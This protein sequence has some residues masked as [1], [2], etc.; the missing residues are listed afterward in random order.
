MNNEINEYIKKHKR[1]KIRK[2]LILFFAFFFSITILI[3]LKA[4]F[5][6]IQ[7]VKVENNKVINSKEIIDKSE[8]YGKN[9]FYI[10]QKDVRSKIEANPYIDGV[11]L[12]RVLPN[13]IVINV[14]ERKTVYFFKNSDG[15]YVLNSELKIL[16]K[17]DNIDG[18]SLTE[19]TGITPTATEVGAYLSNDEKV[20]RIATNIGKYLETNRS[21]VKFNSLQIK[22]PTSI[23]MTVGDV[24]ILLGTDENL[25]DKFNSCIR[26]LKDNNIG[27]KKGYIDVSFDGEP[28]IKQE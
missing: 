6:N 20:K 2:K 22:D 16:E 8:L 14:T 3:L 17:R 12:K 23:T 28:V 10:N 13:G 21:D 9:I 24:R 19:L 11:Q 5:F 7:D 18:M 1:K 4:P 26:I 27:L 25:E 15:I